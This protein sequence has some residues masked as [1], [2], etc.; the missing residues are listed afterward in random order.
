MGEVGPPPQH[1][2][3]TQGLALHVLSQCR[4]PTRTPTAPCRC[5]SQKMGSG[6]PGEEGPQTPGGTHVH[7]PPRPRGRHVRVPPVWRPLSRGLGGFSAS[8]GLGRRGRALGLLLPE[9]TQPRRA[10][11]GRLL[12]LS[13]LCALSSG[14]EGLPPP[15]RRPSL[16]RGQ[17]QVPAMLRCPTLGHRGS[18]WSRGPRRSRVWRALPEQSLWPGL[19]GPQP[20][21]VC[22]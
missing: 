2:T 16:S 20:L 21:P 17:T 12:G 5:P 13:C 18:G 6:S 11:P 10:P 8:Q 4:T 19:S 15:S 1:G 22:S 3:D 9:G 14:E 7:Q